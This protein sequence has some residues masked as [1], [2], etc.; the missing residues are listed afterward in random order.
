MKKTLTNTAIKAL[1]EGHTIWDTEVKG[2]HIRALK[3]A[4]SYYLF[5]RTQH[6]VT[7]RPKL[8]GTDILSIADARE[9]ARKHLATVASGGDPVAERNKSRE[10]PTVK[11]FFDRCWK[12]HWSSK[13][14]SRNTRRLFDARI[15]PRLG[16]QRVRAVCYDDI[17]GLHR[18]LAATPVEANRTLALISKL[19]NL[20]ERYGERSLNSNPCKHVSRYPELSR[21][22][23]ASRDELVKI[24]AALDDALVNARKELTCK[25]EARGHGWSPAAAQDAIASLTFIGLMLFTGMRPNEVAMA[26]R[27]WITRLEVGGVLHLPDSKTGQRPVHLSAHALAAIDALPVPTDKTLTGIQYPRKTWDKVREAAGCP[28]LRL[29]DLRRTFATVSLAHGA[30]ISLIGEVLGHKT[31]QTTKVYARLMDGPAQALVSATGSQMQRLLGTPAP[32]Q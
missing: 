27:E 18:A 10:E 26:R 16:N 30:S 20:A 3:G 8:G 23:F 15:A 28:D 12:S 11:D 5:Y 13:K 31:V 6:G 17:V 4:K 1:D 25:P 14:D 22:R 2:L 19:L 29:Y 7:R 32:S 9:I 21:N 24:G